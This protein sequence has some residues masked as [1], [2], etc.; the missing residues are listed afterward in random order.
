LG[1][2]TR[3]FPLPRLRQIPARPLP[4]PTLRLQS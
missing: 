3:S 4:K 2:A 1:W